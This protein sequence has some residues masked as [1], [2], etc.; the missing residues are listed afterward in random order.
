ML[1]PSRNTEVTLVTQKL[2]LRPFCKVLYRIMG[3]KRELIRVCPGP[4]VMHTDGNLV[5]AGLNTRAVP[6]VC[7]H[8]CNHLVLSYGYHNIY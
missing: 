2:M 8:V 4:L 1:V 3:A 6:Y 5:P 7:M